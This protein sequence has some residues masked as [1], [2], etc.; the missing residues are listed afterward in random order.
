MKALYS[1]ILFTSIAAPS[2]ALQGGDSCSSPT[3]IS[4]VGTF[5][6]DCTSATT[7][8]DGQGEGLCYAF[9]S[10]AVDLDVWFEWTADFSGMAIMTTCGGTSEDTKIA[11]YPGSGCPS[12]GAALACNDDTCTYQS[13][14]EFGVVE[15]SSYML[16]V[17][18]FPGSTPTAGGTFTVNEDPPEFNSATGHYYDWIVTGPIDWTSAKAA[19]EDLAY[20]GVQGHLATV[21]TAEE[22]NFLQSTF[23]ERAWLGAYQDHNDPNYS[24]PAGG[25]VWITGE[26]WSYE[27][28]APGEPSNFANN[29]HYIETF[30]AGD[31]NDQ[32]L[33]GNGL[34][35]GY[36]VEYEVPALNPANGHY[37]DWI[38]TGG[39][40][41][42]SARAMAESMFYQGTQGHLA[43][44]TDSAENDFIAATFDEK[45]WIGAFQDLLDPSYSEP[46]GG[47]T[48]V[49]GE[50][51]SYD[52]WN[53]GEP[54][55]GTNADEHYAEA[56]VGLWND[57]Q[58]SG[59]DN[60]SGF[61][62]EYSDIAIPGVY[63][64][65]DISSPTGCPC[66][67]HG[68]GDEGCANGTGSGGRLRASGSASVSSG[69]VTLSGSQLI[70]SQPGLYFQGN[71]AINAGDGTLFGDGIRCAGG[72]VIRLQVRFADSAGDSETNINVAAVGGVV[73]G[74]TKRYQLWYRDPL[75][76][77]CGAM[78]N[79][80]NGIEITYSS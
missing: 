53:V 31:W 15:G 6:F 74:D 73:A 34:V 32:A 58:L 69:V 75:T 63:C 7:G 57:K 65:G 13:T 2:S 28:W 44:I 36:Y 25:F 5:N 42:D 17:G 10:T 55:N 68:S 30:V 71:N 51:W 20:Q 12:G 62:V 37:Y 23:G 56:W 27:L 35:H 45:A 22:N 50:P 78:F 77:T 72:G 67:N 24:E 8:A 48:W 54:N 33:S 49:T 9:G 70:A 76:S 19:A 39:I 1:L 43:T 16:Q 64:I 18:N 41:F 11:A 61:F 66:N 4:G 14:I 38:R 21:T 59:S 52:A 60:V 3:A 80:T 26:P 40:D 46:A 29:E 47:W 79:L